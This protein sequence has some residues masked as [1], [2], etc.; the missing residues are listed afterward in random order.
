MTTRRDPLRGAAADIAFC[1]C[2]L[3]DATRAEPGAPHGFCS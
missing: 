2:E 1:K 3:L